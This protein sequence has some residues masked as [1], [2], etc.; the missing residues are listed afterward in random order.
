LIV[1]IPDS[2]IPNTTVTATTATT[3]N[4]T[5]RTNQTNA[6]G[7]NDNDNC[8]NGNYTNDTNGS[9]GSNSSSWLQITLPETDANFTKAENE[10]LLDV[11]NSLNTKTIVWSIVYYLYHQKAQQKHNS[12]PQLKLYKRAQKKLRDRYKQIKKNTCSKQSK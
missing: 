11:V 9:N 4:V 5:N 2:D 12:N 8:G 3:N 10:C 7:I 6:D 1:Y